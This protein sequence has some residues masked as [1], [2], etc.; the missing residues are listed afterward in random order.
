MPFPLQ[1]IITSV[2]KSNLNFLAFG[3]GEEEEE[4]EDVVGDMLSPKRKERKKERKG[5]KGRKNRN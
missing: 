4:E 1:T 3:W 5:K 2:A